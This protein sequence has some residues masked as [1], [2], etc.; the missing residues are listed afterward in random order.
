MPVKDKSF[1]PDISELWRPEANIF[2]IASDFLEQLS[3]V[4][5]VS[6][7]DKKKIQN[8]I[9]KLHGLTNHY[10]FTALTL[11][12]TVDGATVADVFVR[13]NGEGKQLN[14]SDFIMT[15]MSVHWDEGRTEL[16]AFARAACVF[17]DMWP[18]VPRACGQSFHDMWPHP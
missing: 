17:H 12:A 15:L 1:I 8:A 13:I 3:S 14:Q 10:R 16:E 9:G 5:E 2:S 6:E 18:P 7:G 4:R 11:S